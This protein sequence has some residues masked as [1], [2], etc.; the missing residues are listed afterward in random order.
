MRTLASWILCGAALVAASGS[1]DAAG[2]PAAHVRQKVVIP[3][4]SVDIPTYVLTE[5]SGT[6]SGSFRLPATGT[7]SARILLFDEG[8]GLLYQV[9][10]NLVR[11]GEFPPP[12]EAEQGGFHG[13]L[14]VI[15]GDGSEMI[16]AQVLGKW[17]LAPSGAGSFG[18]DILVPSGETRDH[19]L[20]PVGA[21][22]GAIRARPTDRGAEGSPGAVD[23][24]AA[25]LRRLT[26]TWIV[27]P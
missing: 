27:A 22:A 3:S 6:G 19:H 20:V 17:V 11:S 14:S 23:R 18:A 10:A 25:T 24:T 4:G 16:V 12:G 26:A 21:I 15:D 13:T 7:G 1:S 2:F 5:G 8:G 9:R